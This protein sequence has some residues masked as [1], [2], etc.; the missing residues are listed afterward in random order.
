HYLPIDCNFY[1]VNCKIISQENS[2]DNH[3]LYNHE[4]FYEH[5]NDPSTRYHVTCKLLSH[6]LIEH[7]LNDG[8]CG[9]ES[10]LELLSLYQ[11]LNLEESLKQ[12]LFN[13]MD[14]NRN[15]NS[16]HDDTGNPLMTS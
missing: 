5:P 3:E 12:K 11:K 13:K 16:F 1:L 9:M 4:F 8:F 6:F 10:N 2:F 7:I 14:C 15:S